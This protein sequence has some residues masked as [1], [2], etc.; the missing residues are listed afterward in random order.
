M[1]LSFNTYFGASSQ[2]NNCGIFMTCTLFYFLFYAVQE[3]QFMLNTS[4]V[5]IAKVNRQ[6]KETERVQMFRAQRNLTWGYSENAN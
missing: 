2:F 6:C 4:C 3:K 5:A 1:H